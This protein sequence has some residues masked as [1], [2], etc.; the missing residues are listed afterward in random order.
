VGLGLDCRRSSTFCWVDP[1]ALGEITT[2]ERQF[3]TVANH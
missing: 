3:G 2:E 1:D